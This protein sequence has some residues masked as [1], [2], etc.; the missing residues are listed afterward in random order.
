MGL[1]A[2]PIYCLVAADGLVEREKEY[3]GVGTKIQNMK[4]TART[5]NSL[6]EP[7][8]AGILTLADVTGCT[9]ISLRFDFGSDLI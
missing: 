8:C 1:R 2:T 4:L 3:S 7:E 6:S 9:S 5:E